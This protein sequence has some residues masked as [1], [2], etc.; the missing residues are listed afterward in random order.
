VPAVVSPPPVADRGVG[1]VRRF[2]KA[3][4]VPAHR[5]PRKSATNAAMPALALLVASVAIGATTT[6][7]LSPITAGAVTPSAVSTDGSVATGSPSH[8]S[9][10]TNTGTN[11]RNTTGTNT[12]N[13]NTGPADGPSTTTNEGLLPA[14]V[15]V[16]TIGAT[17]RLIRL[18][19]QP[20]G[21]LQVPEDFSVA[22]WYER[23]AAPGSPGPAVIAGHVD[24]Y[25]GPGIFAKLDLVK[26]GDPI[27]VTRVDGAELEFTVTHVDQ[28]PKDA[29]PTDV[30]YEGTNQPELRLITCGG[31]FDRKAASY[32]DNVVVYATLAN[33][34]LSAAVKDATTP[35]TSTSTP[36]GT[37]PLS[38][39]PLSTT[40]LST[41]VPKPVGA[42]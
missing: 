20:D 5:R 33:T 28:Y 13:T 2:G 29:F 31:S 7:G 26:A 15:N 3:R 16:P 41:T 1:R 23:G 9:T 12:G 18:G 35:S 30:V 37:T 34:D 10:A 38:T 40:P 21:R 25:T 17:S 6:Y 32:R 19:L 42:P 4:Y 39:T 11:T 24:S 36:L 14:F 8:T 27:F 22:G